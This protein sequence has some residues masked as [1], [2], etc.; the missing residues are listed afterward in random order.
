M[1]L[2]ILILPNVLYVFL[3]DFYLHYNR[4]SARETRILYDKTVITKNIF[5]KTF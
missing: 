2:I 4:G 3:M 1:V 5:I